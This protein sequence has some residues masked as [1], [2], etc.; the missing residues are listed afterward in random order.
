MGALVVH[1][2]PN[3]FSIAVPSGHRRELGPSPG[4]HT[5][6]RTG[7]I[8]NRRILRRIDLFGI[9]AGFATSCAGVWVTIPPTCR[10][11]SS[12]SAWP[13]LRFPLVE[14]MVFSSEGGSQS[15]PA[16]KPSAGKA[17]SHRS[18]FSIHV[19]TAAA[20][21]LSGQ[22]ASHG[23]GRR[24]ANAGLQWRFKGCPL[25]ARRARPWC[26]KCWGVR[27]ATTMSKSAIWPAPSSAPARLWSSRPY[28]HH[29]GSCQPRI[30]RGAYP[31]YGDG[32]WRPPLSYQW[33]LNERPSSAP[34][35]SRCCS[36]TCSRTRLVPIA[37][38]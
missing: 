4:Q 30:I 23:R 6:M 17:R 14:P 18:R 3:V 34:P 38:E 21:Q 12:L 5:S 28:R 36:P 32:G 8:G 31:L 15:G 9:R 11:L 2:Q 25:M 37:C 7:L 1:T 26:S 27:A 20:D 33:R 24:R 13:R 35:M 10:P 19:G 16:T 29:F 22:T